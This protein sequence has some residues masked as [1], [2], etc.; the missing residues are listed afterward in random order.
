MIDN[1]MSLVP[2]DDDTDNLPVLSEN[3]IGPDTEWVDIANQIASTLAL[4]D[5]PDEV[6]MAAEYMIAGWPTFKIS[7]KI[8]VSKQ[9]IRRWLSQY[10]AMAAAV[11]LGRQLMSTW[12]MARLEQQFMSAIERSEEILDLEF[13]NKDVNAKLVGLLAQ[14]ARYIIGLF[15]GQKIDINVN[16]NQNDPV[17]KAKA[18]ALEFLASELAKQ[19]ENVD[20][21]PIEATFRIVDSKTDT[22]PLLDENGNPHH[23]ELGI[24]GVNNS[25]AQCHICGKRFK[26][27][28]LHIRKKH[29]MS[30]EIYETTFMLERNA[31]NDS[32]PN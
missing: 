21:E 32:K 7:K 28:S 30:N 11:S 6:I 12:R 10:P 31:V 22:G 27:L 20:T 17:L 1:N 16:V 9:T 23:G 5:M 26:Q 4:D 24:I 2:L 19:R 25:G 29:N 3:D 13:S 8:N 15:A 18:D 14:H